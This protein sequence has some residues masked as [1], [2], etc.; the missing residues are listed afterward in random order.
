MLLEALGDGGST[1]SSP[2]LFCKGNGGSLEKNKCKNN[3]MANTMKIPFIKKK[4]KSLSCNFLIAV[5][6]NNK[7]KREVLGNENECDVIFAYHLSLQYTFTFQCS[8]FRTCCEHEEMILQRTLRFTL[9]CQCSVK[10]VL[11][12]FG[13][14]ADLE[15]HWVW[16]LLPVIQ[17][18]N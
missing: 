6:T 15:N 11:A 13:P 3:R 16:L 14:K 2:L 8:C 18:T 7:Y 1:C 9:A 17:V 4:K 5:T 12:A 10:I